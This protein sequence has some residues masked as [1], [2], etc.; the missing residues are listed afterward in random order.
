[1]A[2]ESNRSDSTTLNE[3]IKSVRGSNAN[4]QAND[5]TIESSVA[6][7][8]SSAVEIASDVVSNALQGAFSEI[9]W[10]HKSNLEQE[11]SKLVLSLHSNF[12]LL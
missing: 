11:S 5:S 3:N 7:D 12:M 6:V 4:D 10:S 8:L 2:D 1:M 9:E